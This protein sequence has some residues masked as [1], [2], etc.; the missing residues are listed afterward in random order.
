MGNL[1]KAAWGVVCV[2]VGA[3]YISDAV[4]D[5]RE[6]RRESERAAFDLEVRVDALERKAFTEPCEACGVLMG[7][8]DARWFTKA[9]ARCQGCGP[10]VPQQPT[11]SSEPKA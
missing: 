9:G 11:P 3:R 2:W 1:L 6:A 4:S 10:E 7:R 8:D 5:A